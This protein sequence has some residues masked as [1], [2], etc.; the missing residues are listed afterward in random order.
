MFMFMRDL[1]LGLL[2]VKDKE[3]L[4]RL[5]KFYRNLGSLRDGVVRLTCFKKLRM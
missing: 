3:K 5:L 4:Y 2:M 1:I